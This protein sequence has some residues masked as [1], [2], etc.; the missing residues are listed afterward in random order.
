[1][2]KL[3]S[4]LFI[5]MFAITVTFAQADA[6]KKATSVAKFEADKTLSATDVAFLAVVANGPDKAR[7][8]AATEVTIDKTKYKV[9]QKLSKADADALNEK[10]TKYGKGVKEP[11][12]KVRGSVCYYLYCNGYG[13]CYYVYYYC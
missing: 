8:A 13:T 5:A 9:G 11:D 6:K 7:G 12:A 2:K 3:L 4:T 10:A 1:M